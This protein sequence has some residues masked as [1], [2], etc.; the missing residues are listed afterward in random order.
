[1]YHQ[2]ACQTSLFDMIGI[3]GRQCD[4]LWQWRENAESGSRVQDWREGRLNTQ[5]VRS[6]PLV[7]SP[8]PALPTKIAKWNEG[9]LLRTKNKNYTIQYKLCLLNQGW[10]G[11]SRGDAMYL[12]QKDSNC[13]KTVYPRGAGLTVGE[14]NLG[15]TL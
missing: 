8:P 14:F 11:I 12:S 2:R 4:L 13:T 7:L 6:L 1:M 10:K 5:P 15:K 9:K 3:V